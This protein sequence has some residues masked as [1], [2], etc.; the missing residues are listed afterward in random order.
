MDVIYVAGWVVI[1]T[2]A[3]LLLDLIMPPGS[4]SVSTPS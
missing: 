4:A 2:L 1:L 3:R